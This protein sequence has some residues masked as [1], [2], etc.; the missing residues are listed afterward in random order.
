MAF[1]WGKRQITIVAPVYIESENAINPKSYVLVSHGG[2]CCTADP[3]YII[4]TVVLTHFALLL[5]VRVHRT[6]LAWTVA[7][8]PPDAT[9][10][11]LE[12]G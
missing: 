8:P 11:E 5:S 1:S 9:R 6:M 7:S 2:D 12:R 10:W 4:I 3:D